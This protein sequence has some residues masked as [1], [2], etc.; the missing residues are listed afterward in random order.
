MNLKMTAAAICAAGMVS[1]SGCASI[2]GDKD[3]QVTIN[4]TP[5]Q[6]QVVITDETNKDIFQGETP[7]TVTLKKAD[8]SY[9][10]GKHYSV[11]LRKDGYESRTI[12]IS[13]SPNGWYIGGNLV[14]GGL[15]GWLIVDPLTGA[16]YTLSPNEIHPTL[17]ESV[18]QREGAQEL[19]LVL[20]K[21]VPDELRSNMQLLGQI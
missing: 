18:A 9:F 2:V 12:A 11:T 1:L 20:I 17:G 21:D 13:S 6:A 10:G 15:I 5:S 14:F 4:S 8:G 16:M 3:Q 19:N 7:T